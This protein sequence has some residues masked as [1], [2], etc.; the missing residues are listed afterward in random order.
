MKCAKCGYISFD[1]LS[2]CKKCQT[3][4]AAVRGGLG[5]SATKPAVPSLLGSLLRDHQLP[6]AQ[7]KNDAP[8]TETYI[9][10]SSQEEISAALNDGFHT[11]SADTAQ[12]VADSGEIQEDFSLLDLSDE[13]L[14]L[15]IE[16][17]S[18]GNG[19][20]EKIESTD[21]MEGA[22]SWVE[23]ASVSTEIAMPEEIYALPEETYALP[24][25]DQGLSFEDFFETEK[26][27]T[28]PDLLD[29][30]TDFLGESGRL[31][32]API[33]TL[34]LEHAAEHSAVAPGDS[35]NDFVVDLSESELESLLKR[36]EGASKEEA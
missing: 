1:H 10:F 2:E 31:E 35:A 3:S 5:F 24:A 14:E 26:E 11:E 17:D 28:T 6:P 16:K 30:E 18:P 4:I 15:L 20:R 33:L 23:T 9:P 12:R 27:T 19:E 8:D 29:L 21:V 32:D 25:E 7:K 13:E 22:L 34:E 36:L